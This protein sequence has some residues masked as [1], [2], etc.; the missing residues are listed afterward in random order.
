MPDNLRHIQP[1]LLPFE[2][3]EK[4]EVESGNLLLNAQAFY[5]TRKVRV[6]VYKEEY[7]YRASHF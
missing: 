4:T 2:E 1:F 6:V 5:T 7:F 3:V